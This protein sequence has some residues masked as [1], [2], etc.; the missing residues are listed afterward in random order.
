[1]DTINRVKHIADLNSVCLSTYF[2]YSIVCF[3]YNLTKYSVRSPMFS[4]KFSS[5]FGFD[6]H[7]T[8]TS[9]VPKK[10]KPVVLLSSMHHDDEIDVNNSNKIAI[11]MHYNATKSGMDNLDHLARFYSCKR[12]TLKW[13]GRHMDHPA[14][15]HEPPRAQPQ[16]KRQRCLLCARS[17]DK[18]VTTTCAVCC[19]P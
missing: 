14:I 19:N 2:G 16:S 4:P 15:A 1:M 18:N 13:L 9:Y 11:I 7:L 5:M 6:G 12:K 3:D 10:G 17:N 8:P